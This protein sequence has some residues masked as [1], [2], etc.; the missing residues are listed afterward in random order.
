MADVFLS[1]AREDKDTAHRLAE[2]LETHG[3]SV[4]WDAEIQPGE[5]WD[6]VIEHELGAAHCVVVLWSKRS[7]SKEWVRVEASEALKRR[8]LIPVLIDAVDPPLAFR[9]K[10]AASLVGWRGD[11]SHSGLKELVGAIARLAKDP[12]LGGDAALT[13]A[14]RALEAEERPSLRCCDFPSEDETGEQEHASP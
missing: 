5:T 11:Q 4:W 12:N 10:Q 3:W 9:L 13:K 8:V 14:K 1:Y 2:A 6:Q 7:I